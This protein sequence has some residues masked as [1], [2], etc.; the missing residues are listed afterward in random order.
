[1]SREEAERRIAELEE[2][3]RRAREEA[4]RYKEE[5]ERYKEE[6]NA[7]T[8]RAARDKARIDALGLPSF[9]GKTVLAFDE[10]GTPYSYDT[11]TNTPTAMTTGKITLACGTLKLTITI[12]PFSGELRL[13]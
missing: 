6:K 10:L 4:A 12:E 5:A 1:M 8:E 2:Q 9:D 13:N 3:L 11:A 7:I